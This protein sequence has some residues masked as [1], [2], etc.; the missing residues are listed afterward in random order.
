VGRPFELELLIDVGS[1][2]RIWWRGCSVYSGG[3]SNSLRAAI[4]L[5]QS[6]DMF[7]AGLIRYSTCSRISRRNLYLI[8]TSPFLHSAES[9]LCTALAVQDVSRLAESFILVN[10]GSSR[11]WRNKAATLWTPSTQRGAQA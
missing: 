1:T 8:E 11:V 5:F 7:N 2:K 10:K 9:S 4:S 3:G 6:C